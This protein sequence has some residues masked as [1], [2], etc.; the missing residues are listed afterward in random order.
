MTLLCFRLNFNTQH[1]RWCSVVLMAAACLGLAANSLRADTIISVQFENNQGIADP[2]VNYS[3][4]ERDAAAADS[5]FSHS[6][7]WN[8]LGAALS[9][10][11]AFSSSLVDSTGAGNVAALSISRI[12][13][14]YNTGP[15]L[16][17][18][19][20]YSNNSTQNFAIRGLASDSAFTLFLYADNTLEYVNDQGT[21]FTVG[22]S[23]F[24]TVNGNQSSESFEAVTGV[25]TGVTSATGSITGVWAFDS[26]NTTSEIDWSGFQLDVASPATTV[27]EPATLFPA[28][29]ALAL[30]AL[31]GLCRRIAP[32][33]RSS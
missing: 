8:H 3:G 1:S 6:N 4:V 5:Q 27:P 22:S 17:E 11:E 9:Q 10:S 14:A 13:G 28:A 24:D 18:T 23:S 15:D 31:L 25:L 32:H 30:F 33:F 12:G 29:G 16:P 21:I 20:F 7:V 26:E 2:A 19:Y